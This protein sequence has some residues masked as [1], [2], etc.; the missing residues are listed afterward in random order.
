MD[1][2]PYQSPVD[3]SAEE[4]LYVARL[5]DEADEDDDP[6]A[7]RINIPAFALSVVTWMR[8]VFEG[9]ALFYFALQAL[10][11]ISIPG[12]RLAE[13]LVGHGIWCVMLSLTLWTHAHV[14][15]GASA[16]L[17]KRHLERARRA[18]YLALLPLSPLALVS[19]PF[20]L[21][22]LYALRDPQVIARFRAD[23]FEQT[24]QA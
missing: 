18:A 16:L 4:R 5:A 1:E 6:I 20:G 7:V 12:P 21:W 3:V 9:P 13:G 8:I 23:E 2:N 15:R 11:A 22:V 10:L 19:L 14:L 24:S 17:A